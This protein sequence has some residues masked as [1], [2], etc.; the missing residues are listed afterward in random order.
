MP[1]PAGYSQAPNGLYYFTDGSGPYVVDTLGNAALLGTSDGSGGGGGG[2]DPVPDPEVAKISKLI[3]GGGVVWVSGLNFIVAAATYYIQGVLYASPQTNITL[4]AA[5]GSNPRID[6]FALTT[7]GTAVAVAGTAAASP[8]KPE[9][10][11]TTQLEISFAYIA[12]AATTPTGSA[13]TEN[14]YNDG[15]EW[16]VAVNGNVSRSTATPI[17]GTESILYNNAAVGAYARFTDSADLDLADSSNLAFTLL[18]ASAWPAASRLNIGFYTNGGA[19]R[20]QLVSF[21]PGDYG[22]SSS[23]TAAQQ[24]VIPLSTFGANGLAVRRLQITVAGATIPTAFRLDTISLQATTGIVVDDSKLHW[25]GVWAVNRI[26]TLNSVVKY[27]RETYVALRSNTNATPS[28][29]TTD[30][31]PF[32]PI[33]VTTLT[34]AANIAVNA[35]LNDNFRVTLEG[36][37]TLDA[38]TNPRSGQVINFRIIQDGTG[39]RTLAYNAIYHFPGGTDPVLSTAAGAKDFMSCQYDSTDN[40]WFCVMSKAFA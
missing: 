28:T 16:T 39:N 22:S 13:A 25:E 34:D 24:I 27:G 36:N 17:A 9:V 40:T 33:G 38:P 19:L 31:T 23:V 8:V 26:Y 4:G 11:P 10:T 2:T 5:D 3:S 14:V 7:S 20:G 29:S 21:R 37:R 6:V 30:W 35:A 15:T 32:N 1:I 18:N 12:A